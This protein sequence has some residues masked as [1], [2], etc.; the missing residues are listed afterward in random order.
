MG[1]AQWFQPTVRNRISS[2]SRTIVL[3]KF[4]IYYG[5]F[6]ELN[7]PYTE[8][9]SAQGTEIPSF[10]EHRWGHC[11]RQLSPT[12]TE[13]SFEVQIAENGY[14]LGE[15]YWSC[16]Y[17]GSNEIVVRDVISGFVISIDGFN[18]PSGPLGTGTIT[19][20]EDTKHSST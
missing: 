17:F 19:V 6:Y 3:A 7:D 15:V 11:G 18:V 12:G 8:T 13:G 10:G 5:K 14:K 2:F 20:L 1:E 4:T 16:P 9:R